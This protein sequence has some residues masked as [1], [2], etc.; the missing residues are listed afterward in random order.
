MDAT[1]EG[2]TNSAT[3]R[4]VQELRDKAT[5]LPAEQHEEVHSVIDDIEDAIESGPKA[6]AD[7]SGMF[8]KLVTYWPD[9]VPWLTSQADQILHSLGG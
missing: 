6:L 7:I 9:A 3:Q 8:M 5:E 1:E 4:V 2:K